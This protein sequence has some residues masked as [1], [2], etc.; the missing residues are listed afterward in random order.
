MEFEFWQVISHLVQLRW[1]YVLLVFATFF[2]GAGLATYVVASKEQTRTIGA[3]LAFCSMLV[4]A[5][6]TALPE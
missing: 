3:A 4:I 5:S 6:Q 2:T 1:L